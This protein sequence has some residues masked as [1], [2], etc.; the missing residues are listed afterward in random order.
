MSAGKS[1]FFFNE[2][3]QSW[4]SSRISAAVG[5]ALCQPHRSPNRI[6]RR[7][8]DVI[9]RDSKERQLPDLTPLVQAVRGLTANVA[10]ESTAI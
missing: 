8:L 10:T 4:G 3:V 9:R 5:R 1:R 2:T 6:P 7:R